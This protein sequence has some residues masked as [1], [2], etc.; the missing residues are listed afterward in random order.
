MIR[1]LLVSSLLALLALSA[2]S[3]SRPAAAASGGDIKIATLAPRGSETERN[4]KKINKMLKEATNGAWS[5]RFFP[6][7]VA[8]DEKDVI[9]KMRVKQMDAA[10]ITT[11]GLSQIV[12]EVAVLDAPG[13]INSYPEL[14]RVKKALKQ[15]FQE[16]FAAQG[17]HLLGWGE[18]GEYRYF[19][20]KPVTRITDLKKM[21]PWLWPSSHVLKEIYQ[22]IGATGVPL[23][24]P[25][26]YGALQTNMV[27]AVTNTSVGAMG[28]QWWSK[29]KHVTEETTGV[30]LM[31]VVMTNERWASLPENVREILSREVE[32]ATE[33]NTGSMR[34]DDRLTYKK[35]V[36][37]G[38]KAV[39]WDASA[40]QEYEQMSATV[41]ARLTGRI[42]K[43]ELLDK[44]L[45][46]A[47]AE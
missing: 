9:R 30:L 46:V 37:R 44:V 24:V 1:T 42:Y 10:L 11:T 20:T 23:G 35:L 33:Q 31:G 13:V 27:D 3:E 34:M 45:A 28:L 19:S 14:D 29:V 25:E 6:S 39:P 7:G 18:A 26:V 8:G 21:R 47:K 2:P 5:I 38:L 22:T 12:R 16:A 36:K 43:K 32:Q 15:E 40:K 41:R 17:T 4:F